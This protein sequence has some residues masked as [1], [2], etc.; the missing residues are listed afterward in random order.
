[1]TGIQLHW[2]FI[3]QKKKYIGVSGLA[4][5][6]NKIV[7]SRAEH[8]KDF[9]KFMARVKSRQ[10]TFN[11]MLKVFGVLT[12]H[13]H[14]G[15][16]SGNNRKMHQCVEIITG[17]VQYPWK[18]APDCFRLRKNKKPSIENGFSKIACFIFQI[19]NTLLTIFQQK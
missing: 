7:V 16:S 19:L 13:F 10:G 17:M 5:E 11:A 8:P 1:M 12:S 18:T 3:F 4:G 15:T 2:S 9:K 14:H 6:T